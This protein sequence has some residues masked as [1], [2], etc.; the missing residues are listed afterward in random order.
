MATYISI[1]YSLDIV[2]YCSLNLYT[3]FYVSTLSI[4]TF[5][6]RKSAPISYY[7]RTVSVPRVIRGWNT[8]TDRG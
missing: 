5:K 6:T 1:R 8:F 3:N 2:S 4:E 7:N